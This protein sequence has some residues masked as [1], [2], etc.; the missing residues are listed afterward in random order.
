LSV[1]VKYTISLCHVSLKRCNLMIDWM[2]N[3]GQK[4]IQGFI[5]EA[6][7]WISSNDLITNI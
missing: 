5:F 4:P 6:I 7:Y 3:Y 2:Y 1:I